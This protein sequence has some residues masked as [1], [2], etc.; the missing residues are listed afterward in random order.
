MLFSK[1]YIT[2]WSEDMEFK[3][4]NLPEH[5]IS[6]IKRQGYKN[7]TEIQEKAIPLIMSGKDVI[8]QSQTGSGKTAAFGLPLLSHVGRGIEALILTPTRELCTQVCDALKGF[9][10][11]T[12]IVPVY[13]GVG[14]SS[15]MKAAQS[16]NVIVATPGR[17]IDLMQRGL[18][19]NTIKYL[20]LDEADRML[21]MGFINDVEKIIL[22]T[23]KERQTILFSATLSPKLRHIVRKHMK[24]P[25]TLTAKR[26]VDTT[27]LTETVFLVQQQ[28]KFSLLVY[29]LKQ[30]QG[31]AIVF[32]KTRRSCENIAKNLRA[33]KIHANP[34][35]GGMPQNKRTNTIN[36]LHKKGTGILIATDV[37]SRG[38]HIDNIT[39]VYNYELPQTPDDYVHRIGRTARAGA[40]GEAI[41]FITPQDTREFKTMMR[42]VGKQT[43]IQQPPR[44]EKVKLTHANPAKKPWKDKTGPKKTRSHGRARSKKPRFSR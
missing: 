6:A 37:A 21:D 5:L 19:L 36:Q 30:T 9:S 39:H 28:E 1:I 23:P 16:A 33:Q 26:H 35:H 14:I 4:L 7:P 17:L 25:V 3:E 8:G 10:K 31:V 41:T 42:A 13:G 12:R 15:Q 40:S 34:I 43:A 20:V 11:Q 29:L 22:Q 2:E 44:F 27:F 38:L 24:N 18:R 32:C